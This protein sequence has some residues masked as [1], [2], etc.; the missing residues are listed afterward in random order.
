MTFCKIEIVCGNLII[1]YLYPQSMSSDG[2]FDNYFS[3]FTQDDFKKIDEAV[4]AVWEEGRRFGDDSA[5]SGS[6]ESEFPSE[7]DGLNLNLFT[8][9]EWAKLD[10][11]PDIEQYVSGDNEE[12]IDTS[13]ASEINLRILTEEDFQRLDAFTYS[14]SAAGEPSIP[15]ALEVSSGSPGTQTMRVKNLKSPL[16]QFRR[17]GVLSVTDLCHPTWCVSSV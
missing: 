17:Q 10:N 13:F 7:I 1:F 3:G 14:S 4:A 15:I 5:S 8:D 11:L 12:P 6:D 16:R 9:E 2:L